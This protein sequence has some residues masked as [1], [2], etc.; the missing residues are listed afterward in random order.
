MYNDSVYSINDIFNNKPILNDELLSPIFNSSSI[1][2]HLDYLFFNIER[3]EL[4]DDFKNNLEN[5]EIQ[6]DSRCLNP[7][8][9]FQRSYNKSNSWP[10]KKQCLDMESFNQLLE[11]SVFKNN[12]NDND[13]CNIIKTRH[14][15]KKIEKGNSTQDLNPKIQS[16]RPIQPNQGFRQVLSQSIFRDN[17][18]DKDNKIILE[19][20]INFGKDKY[21]LTKDS[22][23]CLI[24]AKTGSENTFLQRKKTN[25]ET[26]KIK[27]YE[28][29]DKPQREEEGKGF[30]MLS[31]RLHAKKS[32]EN[33]KLY[34]KKLEEKLI[35][36]ENELHKLKF[37]NYNQKVD[38]IFNFRLLI[39][40]F[41]YSN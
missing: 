33:K 18:N 25:S 19:K 7:A 10:S 12:L 6:H 4:Q 5:L 16:I 17:L 34:I 13:N 39:R 20:E 14:E 1:S 24:V 41:L 31:N 37:E 35:L 27:A 3:V 21:H 38:Y 29:K 36:V 28:K 26:K 30:H 23:K 11:M 9:Q 2:D 22:G 8:K 40:V 15:I 32:R